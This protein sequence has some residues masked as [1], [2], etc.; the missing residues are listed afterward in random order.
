VGDRATGALHTVA[1]G[2]TSGIGDGGPATAAVLSF[3]QA[4]AVDASGDLFI[5]DSL[6]NRVR[7][8]DH[9]SHEISTVAGNGTFGFSGDGG[10][11]TSAEF[12][13]DNAIALDAA[14]DLFIAVSGGDVVQKVDR[15][16]GTITT[17]AGTG[18]AGFS[19][20]GGPA[21]SVELNYPSGVAVDAAGD[22]FI[23]DTGNQRVRKVDPD[24]TITT[25]AGD[26]T[27]GFSGDGGGATSAELDHPSGIAVDASGNLYIADVA[28]DRVRKVDVSGKITTVA[29][30][31]DPNGLGDGGPATSASLYNPYA[32]A[33]DPAG[34]LFIA[35]TGHNRIRKVDAAGI[36]TTVA[37]D[38]NSAFSGDGGAATSA[39]LDYPVGMAFDAAGDLLISDSS[40]NRIRM[41]DAAGTI[42]TLAG[43]GSPGF[44]GDGGPAGAAKL[45]SP[46][47]VAVDKAGNLFIA[48]SNNARVREV[49]SG[50]P[51]TVT[52]I[53]TS[54]AIAVSQSQAVYGQSIDL[55]AMVSALPNAPSEG[56]VT[57]MDG[58]A[59][60]GSAAVSD[61]KAILSNQRLPAGNHRITASY[62]DASGDDAPSTSTVQADS[63]IKTV[64]QAA[65]AAGLAPY[66]AA[67][68]AAEDVFVADTG[69]NR[70]L[71][72]DHATGNISIVA[73][74]GTH[75]YSGDGG[76]A[77]AAE[78]AAPDA[79]ALD[80]AGDLFI[81]DTGNHR[82]REV[83]HATGN[84]S[85]VAG[86]GTG[87][88]AGDGGDATQAELRYPSR[89]ALDG[90]GDLFIVD[91]GNDRIREVDL[92]SGDIRT[93]AGNG[94]AGYSGDGG[95]AT[96][97][98][99]SNPFG[100]ALDAVGNLFIADYGNQRIREVDHATGSISTVAGN[101]AN[102]FSGDGGAAVNAELNGPH[103]I[104]ADAAGNLFIDDR[105][106]NR[107][108][109]VDHA[110]GMI[111]TL[112]GGAAGFA[113]DGGPAANAQFN[114]PQGVAL[115][116][117][118]D[119]L[120]ADGGNNSI[121]EIVLGATVSISP[122]ALTISADSK[123]EVYGAAFPALTASYSGFVNGD[124]P[125]SLTTR[126][127]L[128]TAAT[129]GS[130]V[131]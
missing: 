81:V 107:I 37:G 119:L 54:T 62:T 104:A 75:G 14:G 24:G 23:A 85:T 101:G 63:L 65:S 55:T 92:A 56:T 48:D 61:G 20:D 40:N 83:D 11:A 6:H 74:N 105:G 27:K 28:F 21:T 49:H 46:A 30:S 121:R 52:P 130:H 15:A 36:I 60:L 70:I 72:V 115:D 120:I 93:V 2:G 29:G 34:N 68:D 124:T 128:S 47:S 126:P 19:G 9:A 31:G 50:A 122:A 79:V 3:P 103:D 67:A 16:T 100:I 113:G 43:E 116:A 88:F 5:A 26:G 39:E 41:V 35:D 51:V 66:G 53:P 57:F 110:T 78:L 76:P 109:E 73:G 90:D 111:S 84:I 127:T 12:T 18:I 45:S 71:R 80:A 131:A 117:S 89:I 59:V 25:V 4:V 22:V 10:P 129:A 77:T 106:N 125:A 95:P 86:D 82:I 97:A 98:E 102:G 99:L 7:E 33:V 38:G 17:V 32:V 94:T 64:A 108:R 13:N 69:N 123:T 87:G 114:M 44:A 8:V 112:A 91:S 42:T 118:G 96:A 58:G 1:G